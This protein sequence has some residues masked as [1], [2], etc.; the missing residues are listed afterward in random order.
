MKTVKLLA[1][2]L[3]F[4]SVNVDARLITDGLSKVSVEEIELLLGG[5][6]KI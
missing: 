3:L 2:S 6:N 1:F 4:L 5:L